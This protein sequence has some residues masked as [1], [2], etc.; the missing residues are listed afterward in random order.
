M[1]LKLPFLGG[2]SATL[3]ASALRIAIYQYESQ[4]T[5]VQGVTSAT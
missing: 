1:N 3:S 2:R 5:I 4:I